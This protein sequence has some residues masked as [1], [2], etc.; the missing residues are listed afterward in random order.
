VTHNRF[1]EH[2]NP[3]EFVIENLR[4][5]EEQKRSHTFLIA[6]ATQD[7]FVVIIDGISIL[8]FDKTKQNKEIVPKHW[9]DLLTGNFDE[10]SHSWVLARDNNTLQSRL[11]VLFWISSYLWQLMMDPYEQIREAIQSQSISLKKVTRVF[12]ISHR[13][14]TLLP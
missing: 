6:A 8:M 4:L 9:R 14:T 2:L 12:T 5:D 10:P 7:C 1:M 3:K 13:S 11:V